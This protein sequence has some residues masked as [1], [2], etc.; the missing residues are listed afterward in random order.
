MSMNIIYVHGRHVGLACVCNTFVFI[1]SK[2]NEIDKGDGAIYEKIIHTDYVKRRARYMVLA[3]IWVS[4]NI[5]KCD[6]INDI[7]FTW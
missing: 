1:D 7:Y 3:P 4:N 6:R 5:I 2:Y